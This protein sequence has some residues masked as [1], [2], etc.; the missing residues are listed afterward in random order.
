VTRIP[1]SSTKK[2][3][4][5]VIGTKKEL[6]TLYGEFVMNDLEIVPP[7]KKVVATEYKDGSIVYSILE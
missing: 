4:S 7:R 6:S 3:T 1:I 5:L 2:L